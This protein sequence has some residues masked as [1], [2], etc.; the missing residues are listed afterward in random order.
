MRVTILFHRLGPYHLARLRQAAAHLRV[1][2]IEYSHVDSCYAW[3]LVRI[4]GIHEHHVLFPER[5]VETERLSLLE[6]RIGMALG[7][8]A[9]EVVVI[10]G[11]GDRC[12][13]A[14]LRWCLQQAVPTVVMSESTAWDEPRA[15]WKEAIKR[16]CVRLF[17]A[18]FV[19]GR[20]HQAYLTALGIPPNRIALGYD[21][22]DNGHF[23]RGAAAVH[24]LAADERCRRGLPPNFFLASARFVETKNL[25]RLLHAYSRYR[26]LVGCADQNGQGSCDP[27]GLVLLG[28]GPL[29]SQ[30]EAQIAAFGLQRWVQLQGFRQYPELPA[31]YGLAGA[32][33]LASIVEPWGLVVNEAMAAGLPVLVSNRCGCA[34]ELVEEASNGFT[35][36]PFNIEELAGR[37]KQIAEPGTDRDAMGRRSLEIIAR[38]DLDAFAQGLVRAVQIAA[39]S[40]VK[41]SGF[42]AKCLLNALL[43]R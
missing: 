27:W 10:P 23:A 15:F 30:I 29:R 3:D 34:K 39:E 37:M 2:A 19:G 28:D 6:E 5:P 8:S 41:R 11:W 35:F 25:P 12:S 31:Y 17:S 26:E 20:P 14:G 36:D 18:G 4:D 16:H 22:V 13:L 38:W 32:F 9:P 24:N 43:R 42:F 33:I 1:T 21:V 7:A 40:P